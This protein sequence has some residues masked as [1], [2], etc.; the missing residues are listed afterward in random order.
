[1]DGG[2]EAGR[3]RGERRRRP[4]P[5]ELVHGL[6]H[7][8]VGA[9]GGQLAEEQRLRTVALQHRRQHP[10]PGHVHA[11][12]P[13]VVGDPVDVAE[14]RQHARGRLGTPALQPRIAV[15]AVADQR[16]VV[17]DR[18]RRHAELRDDT[19]LVA[20]DPAQAVELDD[21]SPLDAL[22]QVLVG[23][24]DEHALDPR[25]LGG[26][27][28]GGAKRVVGLDLDHR[29]DAHA[30][31]GQHLFEQREL[32]PQRRLDALAGL[33]AGPQVVAE[34]L[35]HVV[36]GHPDVRRAVVEHALHRG[37]H[38]AHR[39]HLHARRVARRRHG[40]VVPEELV[41]AV[42]EMHVHREPGPRML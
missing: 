22:R 41:G 14:L 5:L 1:M 31:R 35:D 27:G 23:R 11:P 17:G 24:A 30:E 40:E 13:M 10:G 33:V 15:G 2:G 42:D 4:A 6:E 28:R 25:I 39:A 20:Q 3:Q 38:A 12:L 26:P 16:Q 34:R 32:R 29:P 37:Q 7:R 19:G 18:R 21:A 8:Q 36:G 9:D